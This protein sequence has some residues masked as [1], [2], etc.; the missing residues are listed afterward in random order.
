MESG[1]T[2]GTLIDALKTDIRDLVNTRLELLQLE[3][4]E[5]TS[6]VGSFLIYGL[7]I[8]NL[9]FCAL[10]FAFV[11]LSFWIGNLINSVAGGFGIVS[12]IYLVLLILLFCCRKFILRGIRNLFLK[13]LDPD[14]EDEVKYATKHAYKAHYKPPF[15]ENMY[16][17]D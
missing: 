5:K 17:F 12:L 13:E 10:L 7:I 2:L 4:F 14:L 11:A 6:I 15:K 1:Y 9:V 3:A 8:M 16:E